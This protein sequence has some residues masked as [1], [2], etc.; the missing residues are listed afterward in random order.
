MGKVR[1]AFRKC[2]L[3]Y[4]QRGGLRQVASARVFFDLC[5]EEHQ[6]CDLY[7]DVKLASGADLDLWGAPVVIKDNYGGFFASAEFAAAVK[8]YCKSFLALTPRG[9]RAARQ[10]TMSGPGTEQ[11]ETAWGAQAASAARTPLQRARTR[12]NRPGLAASRG[13]GSNAS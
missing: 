3:G 6:F 1:V 11:F 9:W 7:A 8:D 12:S 13:A 5:L 10:T 4:S 2:V